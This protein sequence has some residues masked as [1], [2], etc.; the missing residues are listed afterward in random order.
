VKLFVA[1]KMP[2]SRIPRAALLPRAVGG[3]PTDVEEVGYPRALAAPAE[4]QRRRPVTGGVSVGLAVSAMRYA[5]TLGAIVC[6]KDDPGMLYALSNNHVLADENRAEAGA[7]VVQPGT[8]DGGA[9]ADRIGALDRFE[10]LRFENRRNW[11]DAALA[12]LEPGLPVA[13]EIL[14]V[15]PVRGSGTPRLHEVVRKAGRTTGLTEGI[16]R[17]LHADIVDI[18]Y[19]QGM[20]RMDEVMVIRGTIDS[21]SRPGDSGSVI[22]DAAGRVI[23]LLFAGSALVTYAIPVGRVLRRLGVRLAK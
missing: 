22:M 19:D 6:A 15:G 21:F 16:V 12:A 17:A 18:E 23:G 20:V 4:R 9:G 13:P 2:R 10:P 8:L 3:I 1:R 11:M 14:G 5:G 7:V